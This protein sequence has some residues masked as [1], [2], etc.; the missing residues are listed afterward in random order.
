MEKTKKR[1][2]MT[3]IENIQKMLEL[4][5]TE[6]EI[7]EQ[8]GRPVETVR[9]KIEEVRQ[10][11]YDQ[12]KQIYIVGLRKEHFFPQIKDTLK[13]SAEL[14]FF[15]EEWAALMEQL[16][17][18]GDIKHTDKMISRD[19]I[20]QDIICFRI[21]AGLATCHKAKDNVENDLKDA[22]KEDPPDLAKI[23]SCREELSAV[24][25]GF[26]QLTKS[27]TDAQAKKDSLHKQLKTTRDQRFKEVKE[28]GKDIFSLIAQMD[29]LK[30]RENEGRQTALLNLAAQKVRKEFM[31]LHE[32]ED[33]SNDSILL[34]VDTIEMRKKEQEELDKKEKENDGTSK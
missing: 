5:C 8:L 6:Y 12:E 27:L 29:T 17:E 7:A 34:N 2:T 18:Q 30:N 32:F 19:L 16:T 23:K 15:E 26:V 33:G 22:L 24:N 9:S 13:D 31:D 28:A 14:R 3:E 11:A 21:T 4:G 20:V 1:V 10:L 25:T